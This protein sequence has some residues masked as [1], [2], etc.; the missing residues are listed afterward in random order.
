MCVPG[1]FLRRMPNIEPEY[2][3]PLSPPPS[4]SNAAPFLPRYFTAGAVLGTDLR[5]GGKTGHYLL[6][7]VT[8]PVAL[9][10]MQHGA[11]HWRVF[12]RRCLSSLRIVSGQA[13]VAVK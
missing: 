4:R 5:G 2:Q 1:L 8:I 7:A 3:S 10:E 9:G 13:E 6:F 12:F 11:V